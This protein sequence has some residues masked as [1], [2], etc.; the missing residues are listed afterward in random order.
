MRASA[1]EVVETQYQCVVTAP[2]KASQAACCLV[3]DPKHACEALTT[4]RL[5]DRPQSCGMYAELHRLLPPKADGAQVA[6]TSDSMQ[7]IVTDQESNRG[8]DNFDAWDHNTQKQWKQFMKGSRSQEVRK[9]VNG[10]LS[11]G[12]PS[13]G[14]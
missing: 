9:L 8:Q 12:V 1:A 11:S 7:D 2:S 13:E 4:H 6:S 3:T 10:C 14:F 5:P